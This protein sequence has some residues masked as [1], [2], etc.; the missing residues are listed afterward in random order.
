MRHNRGESQRG[1]KNHRFGKHISETQRN[2]LSQM[3]MGANN[4]NSKEN[5]IKRML[6][7]R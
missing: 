6:E 5:R 4:P 2:L 3:R 1:V 7:N